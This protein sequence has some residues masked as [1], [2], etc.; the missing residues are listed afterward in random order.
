MTT[1]QDLEAAF[2]YAKSQN[3]IL[4]K[5]EFQ[6]QIETHPDYPSLLAFADAFSF[7]KIPNIATKVYV[8]QIES[9]PNAFVVLLGENRKEDYLAFVTEKDGK[10]QF[11][12]EKQ[13]KKL[14]ITELKQYWR[15]VVFL[16]EKPGD[17][18]S[19]KPKN[20][21]LTS[22]ILCVFVL[23]IVGIIYWFSSSV[24]AVLFGAISMVGIF[25][26]VEALKTELGIESKVSKNMCNIVA[27]ADCSKV[28]NSEKNSWLK[29]F[30]ISDI[31]IWF[32]GSQ[33][34]SLILFSVFEAT[35]NYFSFLFFILISSVSMTLYS[36]Y[37]QY[38]VEKKW[39]PICLSIIVL[40]YVELLLSAI[41]RPA[42]LSFNLKITSLF[43]F[44]FS[45]I[46]FSV[47][48]IKPLLLSIKNLKENNIKNLRLKRNYTFFKNNLKKEE[49]AFF[50]HE[51]VVLGNPDSHLKLSIV[52]SPLCGHC[53]EA[54]EI[55]HEI[56]K[57]N[58][59]KL[60]ISVRFNYSEKF[61]ENTQKLFFKLV[62]IHKEQGDFYFSDA[63]Q[64]WFENKNMKE[65][66]LRFGE[67][68]LSNQIKNEL[69]L[70]ARENESKNLNFT[71][72]IF[73]NQYKF[74]G[75]YDKKD[76]EYFIADLID[77]EEL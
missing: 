43:V 24:F 23:L 64:Y 51:N 29:N 6:F 58:S 11:D 35:G 44:A 38:K 59:Q 3:I 39:C 28:I 73:I 9:L 37:F 47:Y 77:D 72:N 52:T 57:N 22:T 46:A 31:S 12:N 14:N 63:L 69:R 1:N 5:E 40:I 7:F 71:P 36:I 41:N 75:F 19:T 50:E 68:V 70:I 67:P 30:K 56:L 76:L 15:D 20:N 4:D 54:H 10:Y 16:A 65:W 74:P 34:F 21:Y 13:T 33:L 60:S 2:T 55:L 62:E 48:L 18:A 26:S 53:K 66:F 25:L 27:N 42:F 8:D 45:A 49:Q 32:F 61:D 17:F